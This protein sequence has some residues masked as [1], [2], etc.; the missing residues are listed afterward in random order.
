MEFP[1]PVT[2][3]TSDPTKNVF[4]PT[5]DQSIFLALLVAPASLRAREE[6]G[7][8]PLMNMSAFPLSMAIPS[9]REIMAIG[10]QNGRADRTRGRGMPH[11]LCRCR[12]T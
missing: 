7:T 11:R 5:N 4:L 12:S 6:S 1:S 9:P 8:L 10:S 3:I 2:D